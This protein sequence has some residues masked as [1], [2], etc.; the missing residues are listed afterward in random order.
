MP[1]IIKFCRYEFVDA[2]Q[3]KNDRGGWLYTRK[4]IADNL[5]FKTEATVNYYRKKFGLSRNK[6]RNNN[7]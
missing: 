3:A 4:Q 5:G 6:R 2:Y 1:K 7:D